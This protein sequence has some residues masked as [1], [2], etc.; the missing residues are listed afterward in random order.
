[1]KTNI[2]FFL[3]LTLIFSC[4]KSENRAC[5]KFSGETKTIERSFTKIDTLYLYKNIVYELIQSTE[6]KIEITGGKNLVNF[7]NLELKGGGIS[8][9][10]LNK[11]AFLR[12]YKKKVTVKIYASD[13]K[14]IYSESSENISSGN[15]LTYPYL[16]I[17]IRDGAGTLSL[18]V[19]NHSLQIDITS[20]WGNFELRG[21]T[22]YLGVFCRTGSFCDTRDLFVNISC[23]A[24]SKST[25][26][27]YINANNCVLEAYVENSGNIFYSGEPS[28]ITKTITGKGQLI[29]L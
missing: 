9:S 5:F 20:G 22:N 6:N 21:S 24:F 28:S 10:N 8:I 23:F 7:I 14:Y 3:F 2:T 12:S 11:C 18:D 26:D 4:K 16:D 15:T 13:L 17:L 25:G 1:M 19:E 29:A 27:M